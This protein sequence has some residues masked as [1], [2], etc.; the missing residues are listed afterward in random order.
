MLS[1]EVTIHVEEASLTDAIERYMVEKH[2]GDVFATG[3]FLDAQFEQSA[4]DVYRSRYTVAIQEEL[5]R[6]LNEHAARLRADFLRHF[7]G[8]MRITRSVWVVVGLQDAGC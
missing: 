8:G 3:C 6:Y 4:P 5:D 2:I 1:Y 7:P